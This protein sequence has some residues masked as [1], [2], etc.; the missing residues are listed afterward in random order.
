MAPLNRKTARKERK[1]AKCIKGPASIAFTTVSAKSKKGP[2][3]KR[4][5]EK[6]K[7]S[8]I[9]AT[10]KSPSLL[11]ACR[12]KNMR[13]TE[14]PQV[15]QALKAIIDTIKSGKELTTRACESLA[16]NV[17]QMPTELRRNTKTRKERSEE[18]DESEPSHQAGSSPQRVCLGLDRSGLSNDN[19]KEASAVDEPETGESALVGPESELPKLEVPQ[20]GGSEEDGGA[21]L[22]E[23]EELEGDE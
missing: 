18:D 11:A 21:E 15:V 5:A 17:C 6:A 9:I 8:R 2:A 22:K 14:T 23:L 7:P 4:S 10:S 1:N 20:L 13:T 12:R 19:M 16:D 3:G